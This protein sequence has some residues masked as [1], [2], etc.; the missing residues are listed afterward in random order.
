ML[1]MLA[2][3]AEQSAWY[4]PETLFPYL[5]DNTSFNVYDEVFLN[6][7]GYTNAL[8]KLSTRP[9]SAVKL[10]EFVLSRTV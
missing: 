7:I 8:T 1:N 6:I 3:N 2:L 5:S 9:G 10:N 4:A